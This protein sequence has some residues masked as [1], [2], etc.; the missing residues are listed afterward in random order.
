MQAGFAMLEVGAVRSKN[1]QNIL[2]K[3]LFDI[4]VGSILWYLV[5]YGFAY[6]SDAGEFIGTTQFAGTSDEFSARDWFFQWAF[7]ATVGAQT[8]RA[9][10]ASAYNPLHS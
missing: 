4:S 1:A 2:L 7:A 8:Q 5:G 9:V 10:P 3:N 6:G